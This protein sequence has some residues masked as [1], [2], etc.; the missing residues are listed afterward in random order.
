MLHGL[1]WLPGVAHAALPPE[2]YSNAREGA[3]HHLQLRI[4]GVSLVPGLASANCEVRA[5]VLRDFRGDAAA[6]T[7]MAFTLN[8]LAPGVSPMPGAAAW[9]D[10]AALR[11]ARFAE[12][13]FNGT[14][15]GPVYGQ[16]GIVAA[17]RASPWCEAESGRCDLPPAAPP[18]VLE[19]RPDGADGDGHATQ[20]GWLVKVEDARMWYWSDA[21]R[22]EPGEGRGWRRST[23][24]VERTQEPLKVE[25]G[26]YVH[27]TGQY[28]EG[29][30]RLLVVRQL[31]I[32]RATLAFEDD[33]LTVEGG[34]ESTVRGTCAAAADP[35]A[36]PAGG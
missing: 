12:G 7:P 17:G 33:Y 25:P 8:C 22:R 18:L 3:P 26:R 11:A 21:T 10:Y 29:G 23:W 32:D 13:F 27:R 5:T 34:V 36:P 20:H 14:G 24:P 2:Y 30:E 31:T 28:S 35:E 19:C 15:T 6:G 1:A 9:H 4:D 16:L